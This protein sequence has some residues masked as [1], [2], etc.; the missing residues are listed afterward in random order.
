MTEKSPLTTARSRRSR[1]W[2]PL[3]RPRATLSALVALTVAGSVLLPVAPAV[4]APTAG[5]TIQKAVTTANVVPGETF[6]WQVEVGCSVLTQECIGAVL[7]DVMPPEFV[8]GAAST[9]TVTGAGGEAN[10]TAN[11][12]PAAA[13]Y[14]AGGPGQT[15]TVNFTDTLTTPAGAT[16]LSNH[17]LMVTIPV[18]VRGD[19]P[20]AAPRTVTNS[21]DLT[22]D[23]ADPKQASA[24]VTV[25]V[26]LHLSTVATKT[27]S[28]TSLLGVVGAQ[29]T[30]TAAG[31]NTSN[32]A[33]DS[34][35]IQD[36]AGTVG[37][38]GIFASTL[39]VDTLGSV[40]WPASAETATVAVWSSAVNDWVSAAPVAAGDTLSLPAG[41]AAADIRGVRISFASASPAMQTGETASFE[42]G[43]TVR[44]AGSGTRTNVSSSVV[45]VGGA[46]ATDDDSKQL[47]LQAATSTVEAT[48]TIA[49]DR[50][51]SR[52]FGAHD[53][54]EATVTLTGRNTGSVPLTS[55]TIAEPSGA[56]APD[57]LS[58][59]NPLAP[60]H[61]GGGLSF[62][63][64][65]AVVWPAGATAASVVYYY[66]DG[67][68]STP[69]ATTTVDT[70]PAH[71]AGK[72]VTGFEARFTGTMERDARA[73]V[74]FTVRT[75]PAQT[76][77]RVDVDNHIDVTGVNTLGA[78][79]SDD[80]SDSAIIFG[81]RV[82]ISTSKSLTRTELPSV[83]GQSTTARLSTTVL[84]Y[85][86][87]SRAASQIVQYDPPASE[88]SGLGVW[89]TYFDAR[90]L[91]VTSVPGGATLTVQYRDAAGVWAD[92][93]GMVGLDDS[94]SP[95]TV[96]FP[97]ALR[98]SIHGVRT[99]WDSPTG[100]VPGSQIDANITYELR[101]TLRGTSTPLPNADLDDTLVNCSSA[102]ASVAAGGA[103][104]ASADSGTPCP[105]V[106]LVAVPVGPGAGEL[107][108][109]KQFRTSGGSGNSAT[110]TGTEKDITTTRS[111]ERSGVRLGWS[112]GGRT[113]LSQV[114]VTD[115]AAPT[116]GVGPKGMYDAFN[117]YR[118]GALNPTLD[119]LFQYDRVAIQA[120]NP[121]TNAWETP[122]GISCTLA[123]PCT[124][125][126]GYALNQNQRDLYVGV[127]FIFTE[128]PGRTGVDQLAGDGVAVSMGTSRGIDLVYELRDALRSDATFPVVDGPSYNEAVSA[129]GHS[130]IRNDAQILG[131][132]ATGSLDAAT[133]DFIELQDQNLQLDVTKTWTGG[134][135]PIIDDPLPTTR[136]TV[137]TINQT[138]SPS[139]V[140]EL[141]ILEPNPGPGG[142]VASPFETFDLARIQAIAYPTGATGITITV[143]DGSGTVLQTATGSG[144]GSGAGSMNSARTA[145]LG[146]TS[147]QLVNAQSLEIVFTGA[148]AVNVWGQAQFDLVL[149]ETARTSGLAPVEATIDNG[150]KGFVS[151][152]RFDPASDPANPVFVR[153]E[154]EDYARASMQ[155]RSAT[156]G[157]TAGK[158]FSPSAQTEP[159]RTPITMTLSGTPSGTERVAQMVLTDDRATFWNAFDLTAPGTITLPTF[160]SPGGA[161]VLQVE[162]CTGGTF[163][164]ADIAADPEANCI[165]RGGSWQ[166]AGTWLT[167][168]QLTAGSFLPAGITASDVEGLR[169]TVKRADDA[170]WENPQAPTVT[171]PLQVQRRENLRS[172]GAVPTDYAENIP[173]PGE[174]ALG[175]TSNSVTA[176]VT[177]IWGRTAQH[178]A[179]ASYVY[180]HL[181]TAVQV[182]K[183]PTGLRSPAS[184]VPYT[185]TVR[186]TGELPI[187]NPVI[188][189]RLPSDA[190]GAML[191]FDPDKTMQ[192]TLNVAGGSVPTGS[193][194]IPS[195]TFEQGDPQ[196]TITT[197]LD[198]HGPTEIRFAFPAGTVL[199]VGQT[200]TVQV[201]LKFRPGLAAATLVSNT[202]EITGDR[203]FDECTAPAGHTATSTS[204]AK[205]CT[206]GSTVTIDHTPALRAYISDRAEATP[207]I[208]FPGHA[209]PDSRFVGGTDADC[210]LAQDAD[211]FSRPPCAPSTIPGQDSTW[212]LTV[213]NT[214]TTEIPRL[215]VASRL[216]T[217]GDQTIVSDLPRDSKWD[218]VFNGQIT[219]QFGP[220][221]TVTTYYTTAVVPCEGVLQN[222]SNP[223]AC[224]TDPATGWAA[225]PV[226][227]LAD[228]SI[229]TAL[230]FIVEFAP[231]FY[232][233]PAQLVT[234]DIGTT[235][236]AALAVF[237]GSGG[238]DPLAVNSLSVSGITEPGA[239]GVTRISALD[240]SRAVLSL[241]TGSVT[242]SKQITGPASAH[243]PDGTT[244]TGELSCTT[245]GEPFTRDFQFTLTAGVITPSQVQIDDLPGGASCT[246]TETAASGQTGYAATTVVVDPLADATALPNVELVND[247]QYTQFEV[248]KVVTAG[249]GV[250]I[251]TSFEFEVECTFLGAPYTLPAADAAFTLDTGESRVITDIPVNAECSVQETE[252]RGADVVVVSGGTATGG[253]VTEDQ[254]T[255]TVTITELRPQTGATSVNWAEFDNRYSAGAVV[256]IEKEFA[257]GAAD[258]FGENASPEK[259]FTIA[260]LCTFE[261]ATQF[262]GDVVLNAA[263]GWS[264]SIDDLTEGAS[265][266]FTEPDLQG[267]DR[268]VFA[269][270]AGTGDGSGQLTVPG[271]SATATVTAT[272]WYLTGAVQVQKTWTGA[273]AA[274]FGELPGLDYEFTLECT[275]DG[276][277]VVLPGGNTRTVDSTAPSASYTGIASGADCVLSETASNGAWSW[278]VLD[279][280]GDPIVD[281][282]FTIA[283]D[284]SVLADDQAQ[285]VGLV[286]VENFFPFA[287]VSVA[288]TVDLPR[289]DG[290]AGGPFEVELVCTLDGRP[291]LPL[292]NAAQTL[293]AGDT[294]TWTELPA[295]ADC[296]MIETD[297]GGALQ[298]GYR[299][300][301]AD[302]TLAPRVDGDVVQLALLRPVPPDGTAANHVELINSYPLPFT[303]TSDTT[304]LVAG[305]GALLLLLGAGAYSAA[306]VLRRRREN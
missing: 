81:D 150:A 122:S 160:T 177:G 191:I 280:N 251:P 96:A 235:T 292:E 208:A 223:A 119:P 69:P 212:R 172:G 293:L 238:T 28:P 12:T 163:D 100:F 265:C 207:G 232:F 225:L 248:R 68:S 18:T 302:G 53:L 6:N 199:G 243:I 297:R 102:E 198:A 164:A 36:P 113:G 141:R 91:S 50:L 24:D 112:T 21:A 11:V 109:A 35:V 189:D 30:V 86:E 295:G 182:Q 299:L 276:V 124:S 105:H 37:D 246:A 183:L 72:R 221:A 19:L 268:V 1:R 175:T 262:D 57:D 282:E 301:G 213:Q 49:P 294:V 184:A 118:I 178:T 228:P 7:S 261:N 226:G 33:I 263:N 176:A 186:N 285:A 269:P 75:N 5:L 4:A 8:V 56:S 161:A 245:L 94:G 88:A 166:G 151:D 273:G 17:I 80:A 193:T 79:V 84:P 258:Q 117:L 303:G 305:A 159:T 260:V 284:P 9:I 40:V 139:R 206:T 128:R 300:T 134:P 236:R 250:V 132:T 121:N 142:L 20:H 217:A 65:G 288:K 240:Y 108:L 66:S 169:L 73:T 253:T 51:S 129:G 271:V 144:S 192:Y 23:N 233:A 215:V 241:A 227:G 197:T 2:S 152:L 296:I 135:V 116:P 97:G 153:A 71:E 127:R 54:T 247:Y 89:H 158:S 63:A 77:S 39:R 126:A 146:W 205:G 165:E 47:T 274:K 3:A 298:T 103:A 101:S 78:T 27:F 149:R 267:A 55:M 99:V 254:A 138:P 61:L 211:G 74:P 220:N 29:T 52:A 110:V 219:A 148:M 287:E 137:R 264:D 140:S 155:L 16:G 230:Q 185:L 82:D 64:L 107:P 10:F 270:A 125:F 256:F 106:D 15:V 289:A 67:T 85:P 83:P 179:T 259:S 202:F 104:D 26:P 98:D 266:V 162:V 180:H 188:T 123:T 48:K 200:V 252:D 70:L 216:P 196:L 157:V 242:I 31:R 304:W 156:I 62:E 290:S 174:S 244:F 44:A 22:A 58:A 306:F 114:I 255:S 210:R 147:A 154:L 168:A 203:V 25:T 130:V 272:N 204:A 93:P 136:V 209:D 281:G 46:S 214:G 173:A 120:Y 13:S 59:A 194:A 283:V 167:Q 115:A 279:G 286:S 76:Q 291:A 181:S 237:D 170:Q 90:S 14:V 111:A 229:V 42:L 234:V 239:T 222:P 131:T 224:G 87:S 171:I 231:G 95:Y 277:A 249:A 133:S 41:V 38:S 275:R 43:T 257:G 143:R 195:G 60:A 145:A 32:S 278:Q 218:A 201:P 92:V 34:F 187:V 45:G 190:T